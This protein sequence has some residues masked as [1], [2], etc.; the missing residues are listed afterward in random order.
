VSVAAVIA[1]D[2]PSAHQPEVVPASSAAPNAATPINASPIIASPS[3]FKLPAVQQKPTYAYDESASSDED[4]PAPVAVLKAAFSKLPQVVAKLPSA[5]PHSSTNLDSPA[6]SSHDGGYSAAG[7][8]ES[9]VELTTLPGSGVVSQVSASNSP[10]N[11]E[12]FPLQVH[13]SGEDD[14]VLA[15]LVRNYLS[16]CPDWP[17]LEKFVEGLLL[18][19][20]KSKH[21]AFLMES[22][23]LVQAIAH[24]DELISSLTQELDQTRTR[25]NAAASCMME[26][27]AQLDA[28]S[29]KL[30]QLETQN[31][32]LQV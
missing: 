27:L 4:V 17:I 2:K 32:C 6:S 15:T 12:F 5:K 19:V 10:V 8:P 20:E 28:N 18:P 23:H 22:E 13:Q 1:M 29:A 24:Q 31:Q 7:A 11:L 14:I 26:V 3:D 16:G 9:N 30:S 21:A 25:S